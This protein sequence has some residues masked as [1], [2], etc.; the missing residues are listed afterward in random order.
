[1]GYT[2]P[3][4]QRL[5]RVKNPERAAAYA[6]HERARYAANPALLQK[7][8]KTNSER[9]RQIYANDPAYRAKVKAAHKMR[10]VATAPEIVAEHYL[11]ERTEALGGMCPKFVDPSRRGAPDRMVI[12]P[13]Y[14]IHFVEM[15]RYKLGVVRPWQERYHADLRR[16]GH[17][18][19]VLRSKEDVDAFF[20]DI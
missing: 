14:P 12:L 19:W 3:E 6:E 18:V 5:W 9:Y 1:M 17:K 11:R 10:R 15:K 7:R 13:G 4:T 2:K 16:C 8:L 20:A